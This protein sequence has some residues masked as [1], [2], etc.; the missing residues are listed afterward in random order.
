MQSNTCWAI[1]TA[2]ETHD[3]TSR[4]SSCGSGWLRQM[5]RRTA[6]PFGWFIWQEMI[7]KQDCQTANCRTVHCIS[8]VVKLT[9]LRRLDH[10]YP[11][12]TSGAEDNLGIAT[13]A[14]GPCPAGCQSQRQGSGEERRLLDHPNCWRKNRFWPIS[15][16][17]WPSKTSQQ[18]SFTINNHHYP[19]QTTTWIG[20]S[21]TT[22]DDTKLKANLGFCDTFFLLV[23]FYFHRG[24]AALN[25]TS[26]S[27]FSVTWL[28]TMNWN[29]WNTDH[30]NRGIGESWIINISD[31]W[32]SLSGQNYDRSIGQYWSSFHDL[33][34]AH[35]QVKTC[36]PP[37]TCHPLVS[38]VGESRVL[39]VPAG[40]WL[41]NPR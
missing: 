37:R 19:L 34:L 4:R 25:W 35:V 18:P 15:G 23:C 12:S 28:T 40:S 29:H 26:G 30:M 24:V 9:T 13:A 14:I 5:G 17:R 39:M 27:L 36:C 33:F 32:W 41:I 20:E 3:E 21:F 22:H 31:D 2:D 16:V 8:Q 38:G 11:P 6:R 1:W 7:L 10:F